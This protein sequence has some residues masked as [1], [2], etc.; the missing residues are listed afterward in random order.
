MNGGIAVTALDLLALCTAIGILGLRLW[1]FPQG[2]AG[3]GHAGDRQTQ[4]FPLPLWRLLGLCLVLLTLTSVADLLRRAADMS[5]QPLSELADFLPAVVS[6]THFGRVWLLRPIALL[7]LWL[8]WRTGPRPSAAGSA[9]V[10]L[11]FACLV[12]ASRS[13]SGHAADSGD[14]TLPELMDWLHL[15]AVSLWGG[16]LVALTVTGFASFRAAAQARRQEIADMA[17][18]WSTLSAAAL[19]VVV[20]T[21]I[22]NTWLQVEHLSALWETA[23]GG[24]LLA[25]LALVAAVVLLGAA[26]RYLGVPALQAWASGYGSGKPPAGAVA[27]VL[28]V[29][30]LERFRKPDGDGHGD[31]PLAAFIRRARIEGVLMIVTVLCAAVLLGQ[32]PARHAHPAPAAPAAQPSGHEHP[33]AHDHTHEDTGGQ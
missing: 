31:A 12:A 24:V 21:G 6:Q 5:G 19:G 32:M 28:S 9:A 15:V 27:A 2:R 7:L 30:T 18:R 14:F 8:G 1:V 11:A 23:Y 25:K 22:Y 29:L 26:N 16:S 17:R 3:H 20:V 10:M 33:A 4:G 13:L